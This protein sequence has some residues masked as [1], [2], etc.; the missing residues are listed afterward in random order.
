MRLEKTGV[1]KTD[2][3]GREYT[4]VQLIVERGE[5]LHKGVLAV[6]FSSAAR[7]FGADGET[8]LTRM[9][10]ASDLPEIEAAVQQIDW[11]VRQR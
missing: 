8:I 3:T 11:R 5:T 7:E 9:L 2:R 10:P 4:Q 1:T 6:P